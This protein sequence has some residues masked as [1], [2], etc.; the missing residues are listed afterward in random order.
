MDAEI[1][2]HELHEHPLDPKVLREQWRVDAPWQSSGS[3]EQPTIQLG[4]L[5]YKQA[6]QREGQLY[7][8]RLRRTLIDGFK[9]AWLINQPHRRHRGTILLCHGLS[10]EKTHWLRFARYF[11]RDYRVVIVDFA[12]HGQTGYQPGRDYSTLAQAKRLVDLLDYLDIDQVH[13][14]GN[15][16]G[17]LIAQRFALI[18]P[19]RVKSLGLFDAAGLQARHNSALEQSLRIGHN[20]FIIHSLE[21]FSIFMKLAAYRLPWVPSQVRLM[22]AKQYHERRERWFDIFI[23]VMSE[24]YPN[25][26]VEQQIHQVKIP[27]LVLWGEEDALLEIDMLDHY[28]ELLPHAKIVRMS[29]TGHL[30]MLERPACSAKHYS[31]FLKNSFSI[32]RLAHRPPI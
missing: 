8:L 32:K 26:W 17:G 22:L 18:A 5:L 24:V 13:V 10:S 20:P 6:L 15:S 3:L 30:P 12:G 7:G 11:V 1:L 19:L 23:Q 2:I 29:Q 16:M 27:T 4:K 9:M 31:E 21:E 14:V 25:S 28:A